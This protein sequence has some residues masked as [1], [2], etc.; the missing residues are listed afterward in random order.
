VEQVAD[1]FRDCGKWSA[2]KT[3]TLDE[4]ASVT[5]VKPPR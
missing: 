1:H 5:L 2:V 4:W 3:D